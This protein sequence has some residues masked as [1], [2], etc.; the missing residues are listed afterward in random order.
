MYTGQ[1]FANNKALSQSVVTISLQTNGESGTGVAE[2]NERVTMRM[3]FM[4][5]TTF[6]RCLK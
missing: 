3:H 5:R 1:S 6:K 2:R 4:C